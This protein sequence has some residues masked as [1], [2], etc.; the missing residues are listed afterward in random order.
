MDLSSPSLLPLLLPLLR[1][2][3]PWVVLAIVIG[4]V[5]ASAFYVAFGRGLR[6]LPTYVA[7]GLIAAPLFQVLSGPLLAP[8]PPLTIGEVNL[9]AV[10]G[11]T[12][13]VLT[14][15]RALRL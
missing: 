5:S 8:P 3:Y 1:N 9:L 11:G 10:A 2:T 12:W 7:L 15:A 6:S 13:G 14:I 4:V